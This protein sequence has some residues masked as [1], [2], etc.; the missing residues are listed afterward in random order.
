M[1]YLSEIVNANGRQVN[2][3]LLTRPANRERPDSAL[4][5]AKEHPTNN[6]WA[7]WRAFWQQLRQGHGHPLPKLGKWLMEPPNGTGWSYNTSTKHLLHWSREK[8]DGFQMMSRS[9]GTRTDR[10]YRR[11]SS[12]IRQEGEAMA[13]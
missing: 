7:T 2:H 3:Q 13:A 1:I 4:A 9:T 8:V 6:D 12:R 10:R 11:T 5:P